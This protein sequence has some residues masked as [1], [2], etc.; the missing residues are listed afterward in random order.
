MATPPALASF[1]GRGGAR[2]LE[3]KKG[4]SIDWDA[5]VADRQR[6]F[7]AG[8]VTGAV[9]GGILGGV[10]GLVLASK[11]GKESAEGQ[12]RDPERLDGTATSPECPRSRGLGKAT[13]SSLRSWREWE[14]EAE[15]IAQVRRTLEAKIAELNEAIQATRAQLLIKET[16]SQAVEEKS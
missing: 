12:G 6:D 10:L 2:E 1:A 9:V 11:L 3:R 5:S 15:R 8:V 7:I 16:S 4:D 13:E 14:Q